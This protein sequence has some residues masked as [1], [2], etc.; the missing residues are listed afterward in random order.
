MLCQAMF[1]ILSSHVPALFGLI[2]QA[3][4][5]FKISNSNV[6]NRFLLGVILYSYGSGRVRAGET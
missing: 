1:Y 2:W 6:D 3:L 4:Q 5:E